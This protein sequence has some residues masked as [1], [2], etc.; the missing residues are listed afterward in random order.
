MKLSIDKL[1]LVGPLIL[2]L[3]EGSTH[4]SQVYPDPRGYMAVAQFFQGRVIA[5]VAGFI[6]LR[7]LVPFLASLTNY[8]ADTRTSF[9]IV[10]LVFW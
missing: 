9:A 1:M 8:L 3:A 2:S 4:Y 6:L 7:S 10:N 5:T